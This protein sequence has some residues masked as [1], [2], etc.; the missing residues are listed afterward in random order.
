[1]K[2][3]RHGDQSSKKY[4]LNDKI[5]KKI[6]LKKQSELVLIFKIHDRGN[7]VGTNHIE[8]KSKKQWSKTLNNKMLS[9]ETIKLFF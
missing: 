4:M 3:K 2:N 9:N 1:V 8:D 6:N 7:E 5:K